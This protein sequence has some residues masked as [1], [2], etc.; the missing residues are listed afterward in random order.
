MTTLIIFTYLR[1][2]AVVVV[3]GMRKRWGL[4]VLFLPLWIWAA[5]IVV[6]WPWYV[7]DVWKHGDNNGFDPP[8]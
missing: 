3:N 8:Q 6:V 5:C 1:I 2:G 4:W 7:V